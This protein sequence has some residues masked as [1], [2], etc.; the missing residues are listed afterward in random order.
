MNSPEAIFDT[1]FIGERLQRKID[2]FSEYEIQFFAY[3]S[4]L[5]SLYDGNTAND[6]KYSFAKTQLGSPFSNEIS[7]S[8]KT[9]TASDNLIQNGETMGYFILTGSGSKYLEFQ[10]NELSIFWERRKYL[11]AACNTMSLIPFGTIKDAMIMEPVLDS[12]GHSLSPRNLL[13]TT[14]PAT[15]VLH[16]QFK[17]L[18]LALE[19]KYTDL[20]VPAVVWLESLNS[21]NKKL[22]FA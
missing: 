2:D 22:Q 11:Q 18:K 1:L 4:C 10:T 7:L 17:N 15:K 3:F 5:L 16:S 13:E 21:Q 20:I 9:L 14:N 12:A 6:W 8:I 19:N